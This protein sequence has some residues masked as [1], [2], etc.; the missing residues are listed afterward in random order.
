M[1]DADGGWVHPDVLPEGMVLCHLNEADST[2]RVALDASEA[3][4]AAGFTVVASRQS[5]GRGRQG[6]AWF[7]GPGS[8]AVS[9]LRRP[10][11]PPSQAWAMTLAAGLAAQGLHP[12]TWLKWPN[13]LYVGERKAGGILCELRTRSERVQSVVV[14]VGLNLSAPAN[15]WPD[16][17][18]GRAAALDELAPGLAL[19]GSTL[20]ALAEG[21]LRWEE[22]LVLHGPG[23]LV[24]AA[25]QAMGPMVGRTVQVEGRDGR[26]ESARVLGIGQNGA[27][28]VEQGG[29]RRELL[30]G[31][32]HLGAPGETSAN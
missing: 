28:I 32:V 19:Q 17:L 12:D 7:T 10:D 18:Q 8:L 26:P 30:A 27:L 6:R 2:N 21:L 23:P 20:R 9:F 1:S 29:R 25:A 13:D 15:G 24:R 5:A 3:G 22:E 11:I 4:M 14:G 31:D 16:G